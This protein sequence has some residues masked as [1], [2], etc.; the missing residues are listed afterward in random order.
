M[1]R[2]ARLVA[3]KPYEIYLKNLSPVLGKKTFY[4]DAFGFKR[5]ANAQGG[6]TRCNF[7]HRQRE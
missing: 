3:L 7:R 4:A 6:K 2:L 5:L 1:R